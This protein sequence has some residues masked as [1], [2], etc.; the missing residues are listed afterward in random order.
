MGFGDFSTLVNKQLTFQYNFDS[1][2][3]LNKNISDNININT[4]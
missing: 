4:T 2:N 3:K 1:K